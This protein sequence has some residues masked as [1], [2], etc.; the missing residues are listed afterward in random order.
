MIERLF[1][2]VADLKDSL[3]FYNMGQKRNSVLVVVFNLCLMALATICVCV[4]GELQLNADVFDLAIEASSVLVHFMIFSMI[5]LIRL[6]KQ[7]KMWILSGSLAMQ[8]GLYL[9]IIDEFIFVSAKGWEIWG[10]SL[11]LI[12]T[13]FLAYGIALWINHTYRASTLDGLT[14]VYNRRFFESILRHFLN[15]SAKQKLHGCMVFFDLD[16]F[17]KV[18]DQWGHVVGDKVLRQIA[19]TVKLQLRDGDVVCRSGGEEFEIF[20]PGSSIEQ[21]KMVAGRLL[22]S[23]H[24]LHSAEL[25][26]VTASFGV[27]EIQNNDTVEAIRKRSDEAMYNAKNTGKAQVRVF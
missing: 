5:A 2:Q 9:N 20:L 7:L 12:G 15:K 17:K 4:Y 18:N 13:L 6:R 10:D 11:F 16:D 14:G 24:K 3:Y 8:L 25:P 21:A 1:A 23:F 22:D 27:T 26:I 19:Q